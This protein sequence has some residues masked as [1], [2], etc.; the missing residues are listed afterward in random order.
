MPK[1][2]NQ[3]IKLIKILEILKNESDFQNPFSTKKLISRLE[4]EGVFVERKT[5]YDDIKLLQECGYEIFNERT[6]TNNY[7]IDEKP[8][9]VAEVRILLDAVFSA[10][11]ITEKKTKELCDKISVLAGKERG[12]TINTNLFYLDRAKHDNEKIFYNID[13]IIEAIEKKKKVAFKYFDIDLNGEKVLRKKGAQYIVNPVNLIC[14]SDNY[15]LTSYSDKYKNLANYRVDRI[16]DVEILEDDI[17]SYPEITS[18]EMNKYLKRIFSMYGGKTQ[19]IE[20]L[21]DKKLVD[22]IYDKF[23]KD[24]KITNLAGD[25]FRLNTSVEVSPT[26][27]GWLSTFG[28]RMKIVAPLSMKK[29]FVDHL[30]RMIIQYEE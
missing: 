11:F 22:I 13:S 18:I 1:N 9:S 16:L 30:H 20:L 5:L 8:L 28:D 12:K 6:F 17:V 2:K 3:K 4:E 26:F 23:G 14:T 10:K 19:Y 24:V 25:F 29:D 21:V 27:F 7:Y 15:Y